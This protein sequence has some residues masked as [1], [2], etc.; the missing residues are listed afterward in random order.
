MTSDV[1]GDVKSQSRTQ[2]GW[3]LKWQ[4][5]L[6]GAASAI[7][8]G[9]AYLHELGFNSEFGIPQELIVLNLTTVLTTIGQIIGVFIIMTLA[10]LM[11]RYIEHY[12]LT[13][14]WAS[15]LRY[16]I[17]SILFLIFFGTLWLAYP[18]LWRDLIY[19]LIAFLISVLYFWG[20]HY[21]VPIFTQRKVR[22]YRQKLKAEDEDENNFLK[23]ERASFSPFFTVLLIL[24]ALYYLLS[25]AYLSGEHTARSKEEFLVTSTNSEMVVLRI[26]GDNIVCAPLDR[27]NSTITK[28]LIILRADSHPELILK[29]EDVGP[30]KVSNK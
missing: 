15:R 24:I 8:Y 25:T 21:A 30:L 13:E 3:L 4:A 23:R 17:S 18:T 2:L 14:K 11:L 6:I 9:I 20:V 12:I 19:M 27:G 29:L 1:K 26:Y 16:N 22:G 10:F 7:G 5:V 28:P